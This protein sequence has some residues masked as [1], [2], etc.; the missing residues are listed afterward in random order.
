[1]DKKNTL[2]C[3]VLFFVIVFSGLAIYLCNR[4][5][6]SEV[7]PEV[8]PADYQQDT[9][10]EESTPGLPDEEVTDNDPSQELVIMFH[11][12]TGPMCL[13]AIEFFQE[14]EIEYKEHLTS[15]EDFVELLS[16]TQARYNEG[17]E[18]V[19]STFGYYPIIFIGNR[20]FSGFNDSVRDEIQLELDG[21]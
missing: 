21:F 3:T 16:E 14:N 12:G 7:I 6:N 17:S 18:G 15:D 9:S 5:P 13:E 11:N 20:A 19:S 1:M 10:S 8:T 2:V 4:N